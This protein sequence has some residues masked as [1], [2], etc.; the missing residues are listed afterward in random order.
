M[1]YPSLNPYSNIANGEDNC[2]LVW[3]STIYN[4]TPQNHFLMYTNVR[5][6]DN[7]QIYNYCTDY[8]LSPTA[9]KFMWM[10]N[11]KSI[12]LVA[13]Y[14]DNKYPV[15][16]RRIYDFTISN[17]YL[18]IETIFSQMKNQ[19]DT[20]NKLN[21][22]SLFTLEIDNRSMLY[23]FPPA[24][25]QIYSSSYDLTQ[26]NLSQPSGSYIGVLKSIFRNSDYILNFNSNGAI[27]QYFGSLPI[28]IFNYNFSIPDIRLVASGIFSHLAQ[29]PNNNEFAPWKN[30]SVFNDNNEI[31]ANPNNFFIIE[32]ENIKST[33]YF[34]Y[35]SDT[36]S[37]FISD[38][39]ID[40]KNI[41]YIL[42]YDSV[43]YQSQTCFYNNGSDTVKTDWFSVMSSSYLKFKT[44][45][46]DSNYKFFLEYDDGYKVNLTIPS[47]HQEDSCYYINYNLLMGDA[48]NYRLLLVNSDTN[49]TYREKLIIND[50]PV[51]DTLTYQINLFRQ[52]ANDVPKGQLNNNE[53]KLS[54]IPNPAKEV[55]YATVSM[56]SQIASVGEGD[57]QIVL[58]IF[59]L[60]G[61]ELISIEVAEG[62]TRIPI[63]DLPQGSYLIRAEGITGKTTQVLTPIT[64]TFIIQR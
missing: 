30:R 28:R 58:K 14:G 26:P 18:K 59:G 44:F 2:S 42:P 4:G 16:N 8:S 62:A 21:N 45:G 22:L 17:Y 50:M 31:V 37:V 20:L 40:A 41:S 48:W 47:I 27:Y 1:K 64:Q 29:S 60:N 5:L 33:N 38:A 63:K 32:P 55:I 7:N 13:I 9:R 51:K 52:L 23:Y 36:G 54:I 39:M 57:K 46:L 10:N 53:I 61:N 6:N 19:V 11:N 3:V 35:S 25:N 12:A 49:R 15:I 43:T 56:P 24:I 34:G